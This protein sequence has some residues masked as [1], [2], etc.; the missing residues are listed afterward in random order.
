MCFDD[1]VLSTYIDGELAEPWK[2]QVEEHLLHCATCKSRYDQ[3]QD[4]E[5]DIKSARLREDEFSVQ[6]ERV[7]QYLEKHCVS[8]VKEK[9]I[10]KR[11]TFKAP[12]VFAAAAAFVILFAAGI[13]FT[14]RVKSS[15]I[16]EI[17]VI[18]SDNKATAEKTLIPVVATDASPVE[19]SMRDLTI[20]EILQ[21][22]DERGFEVDLRLKS[23][24]PLK[25]NSPITGSNFMNPVPGFSESPAL[26]G[27]DAIPVMTLE[28]AEPV[29][30][31]ET[32]EAEAEAEAEDAG[33]DTEADMEADTEQEA[34][35]AVPDSEAGE[36]EAA[37]EESVPED[38][39]PS[40]EEEPE[41]SA[42]D[43][44]ESP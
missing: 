15:D 42:S 7:W 20:E 18:S 2:T 40:A 10:E 29:E 19:R 33:I 37:E 6:R 12:V 26:E 17:P 16:P 4:L 28:S 24:E 1:Q 35:P 22:L 30:E 9:I 27:V 23:V 31:T 36:V 32:A 25:V 41:A 3:L 39:V 21:L 5:T 11:F 8:S 34:Q 44:T 14:A 43:D 13:Y 38:S